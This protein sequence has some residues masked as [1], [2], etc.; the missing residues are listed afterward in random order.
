MKD[1][2][3]YLKVVRIAHAGYFGKKEDSKWVGSKWLVLLL[4]IHRDSATNPHRR[5]LLSSP[6]HTP[7]RLAVGLGIH[8]INKTQS[9]GIAWMEAYG[10]MRGS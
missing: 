2:E 8:E 3:N 9:E 6:S 1:G 7:Q 10:R 4:R 5:P